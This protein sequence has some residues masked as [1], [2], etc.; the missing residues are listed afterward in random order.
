MRKSI[1]IFILCLLAGKIYAT[2]NRA[3][4]ITCRWIGGTVYEITVITYTKESSTS[5]DRDFLEIEYH[6]GSL[7]DSIYRVNGPYVGG[8]YNGESIGNDVKKNI[9][10]K[11][12]AF[13]GSGANYL[14]SI[15]DPNRN[16]GVINMDNSIEQPFYIETVLINNSF[17]GGYN[18]SPIL[19]NPPIDDACVC[20][21]FVHNPGAYD[22]DGDSLAYKLID[23]RGQGGITVP[24]YFIPSGI[25]IDA[26]TGDLY[27]PCPGSKQGEYNFAIL[28]EEWKRVGSKVFL[29]GSVVRDMQITVKA[30]CTNNPPVIANINDTCVIAGTQ[31]KFNVKATDQDTDDRI[32]LSSTGEPYLVS[33]AAQF[34][35]V[36]ENN[37]VESQFVWNTQCS[38]V[39]LNSYLV[40]FKAEDNNTQDPLVD[41]QSVMIKVIGPPTKNLLATPQGTTIKL[42]WTINE[43]S[44]VKGYKIYRKIA[45]NNFTPDYCE[46]GLNPT[47]GYSLI[48]D[49]ADVG[50]S[51]F[52]DNN[53]GAGLLPGVEYCYRIVAYFPDGSESKV[54]N[55]TCT[56]LVR[57]LPLITNVSVLETNSTNGK[58]YIAWSKPIVDNIKGLDTIAN[59]GPYTYKLFH[60]S[61]LTTW[62]E[63][64]SPRQNYF[65]LMNDT[66]FVQQ[67]VNTTIKN[68]FK[69]EFWVNDTDKIGTT[70]TASSVFLTI[71]PNDNRLELNWSYSVPWN[72]DSFVVYRLNT[73]TGIYD[74]IATTTSIG[75]TDYNL[76]NNVNYCYYVKSIGGYSVNHVTNP[77]I[78]LSQVVCG[79]PRDLTA[80]CRPEVFITPDC[81]NF[82]NTIYWNKPPF[83]CADDVVKYNL[84]RADN[85]TSEFS[86]VREFTNSD[87]LYIHEE[88]VNSIA[89][90]YVVTAIDSFANESIYSDTV[91]ADN[92]PEYELPN[93][94]TPNGDGVNDLFT[95][96]PRFRYIKDIDLLIYN[97]WGQVVFKTNDPKIV[98]NGIHIDSKKYCPD[99][100][101]YYIC[102]VNQIKLA[103]I[104]PVVL[105]GFVHMYID[106]QGPNKW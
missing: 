57:D 66:T 99:G 77:L 76:I 102:T 14:I 60:S 20:K 92:C 37:P 2:H 10:R 24:G 94:F 97:R 65:A 49:L 19:Q 51:S 42:T 56:E 32:F 46:T 103:G 71:V 68:Y 89:G 63:I 67:D 70:P 41:F 38:N 4:E 64:F 72:N 83:V 30:G 52:V 17:L 8:G 81:E 22:P 7:T 28:I 15:E 61:D 5:A 39:R 44:Q 40:T 96:L 48:K 78:N 90:C 16:E 59:S 9:Y 58:I 104:V 87:T 62:H 36:I 11:N 35:T 1:F 34:D 27:W 100:V 45:S 3:G 12:H 105:K 47:Y 93:V 31:L 101:Y 91:C 18:N 29:V 95:P 6:D 74:S 69:L 85:Q 50:S 82:K 80:P 25:A 86:L 13:P 43:C 33:N 84:Y 88:L 21:P 55:E 79:K 54:S 75:Y 98:W 26:Y 53:S 23:C 106:N 73:L